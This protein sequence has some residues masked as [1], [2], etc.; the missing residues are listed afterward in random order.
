MSLVVTMATGF[1]S[2][3]EGIRP[4]GRGLLEARDT[5]IEYGVARFAKTRVLA[6][7]RL[8]ARHPT[9]MMNWL[10]CC[11]GAAGVAGVGGGANRGDRRYGV[12]RV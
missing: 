12:G 7:N 5:R 3:V 9:P 1:G 10:C 11:S 2:Q 8:R 4:D 6:M